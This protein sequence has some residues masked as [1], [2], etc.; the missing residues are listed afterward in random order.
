[1]KTSNYTFIIRKG[2][3]CLIY[4]CKTE[5]VSAI[6]NKL[7]DLIES[8]EL[9][10]I[11]QTHPDFFSFLCQE[12]YLVDDNINEAESVVGKWKLEEHSPYISIF[13]N[14]IMDC[15]LKCWYCYEKHLSDSTMT[16]EVS[17][18]IIKLISKEIE[19][20]GKRGIFI[21]FFGGEPLLALNE[22]IIPFLESLNEIAK[23]IN[24]NVSFVT[25]GVLLTEKNLQLLKSTPFCEKLTFQVTLDGNELYHN[26]VKFF[27][28]NQGT[29]STIIQNIKDALRLGASITLRFN[30][31]AENLMSFTDVVAD[32]KDMPKSDIERLE[33]DFQ[34]VWQDNLSDN[35]TFIEKQKSI[36]DIF[37][38]EGF[39]VKELKHIDSSRCYADRKNHYVINYN[40]DVYKC[41]AR[42]FSKENRE[43]ILTKEGEVIWNK[44]YE[45][46]E[47]VKFGN[48]VCRKCSI[49]PICH[50]GC[51]QFKMDYKSVNGCLRGYSK[52]D[53]E[54]II[55]DR[56]DYL[57]NNNN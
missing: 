56:V 35:M 15:N 6:D 10:K 47:N 30:T 32:L 12:K 5:S 17:S 57:I 39:V 8:N 48:D 11:E 49:F 31:T 14:P 13:I 23:D 2:F 16:D 33:I 3:C 41:T 43:G 27:N 26:K 28:N 21:S 54:K 46:R 1:M 22:V 44:N 52:A 40:C 36:R 24:V 20:K 51:S 29:Y 37:V 42:D 19:K 53:K 50:G 34:H 4:N 9:G 25:N 38:K 18:A 45:I 55:R 7:A